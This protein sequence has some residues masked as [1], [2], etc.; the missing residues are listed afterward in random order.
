[1]RR[2]RSCAAGALVL[3]A[4][5]GA[6]AAPAVAADKAGGYP[7]R[8]VRLI[9]PFPPGGGTDLVSRTIAP[10]LSQRLG[11]QVVIDNRGAAQGIVG[12][13]IAATAAPDGY[14]LVIAEIGA[15]AVAPA[16]TPNVPFDVL[17]DF[18]PI[19]QLIS[20]PYIMAVNPTVPAKTLAEFVKLAQAKPGALN[21]GSGNVTAHVMQEVFFRT[22]KVKLTHVPYRGSGPTIAALLQNEIQTSFSGPGAALPQI[23]AG[24]IRGLAVTT[25]KR[26]PQLPDIPTMNESGYKGFEV[27]GW[28]GIMAPAKTPRPVIDRLNRDIV[29]TLNSAEVS[30]I[31]TSRG[32]DPS[33]TTPEAFAKYLRSEIARWSKA[34]KEYGIKSID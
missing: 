24:K 15:T 1:M 12:T 18:A 7:D 17:K 8:P 29:A 3:T 9:V 20:Q 14:T 16:V 27:S 6:L 31:L 22:A 30:K 11:Q 2:T 26:S 21:Y 23:K 34:V 32:Y 25:L 5:A 33:P 4:V 19:T 10:G 13:H 28:Y